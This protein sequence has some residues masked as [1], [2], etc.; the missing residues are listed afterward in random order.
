MPARWQR[1]TAA[2]H[3]GARRVEQRHETDQLETALQTVAVGRQ[4]VERPPR[5]REHA[6]PLRS[7]RLRPRERRRPLRVLQDAAVEDPLRRA[8]HAGD[9]PTGVLLV[10]GRHQLAAGV[11]GEECA[12]PTCSGGHSHVLAV[13]LREGQQR[14]LG[15]VAVDAVAV[16]GCLG[17]VARR[18]DGGEVVL[19]APRLHDAHLVQRQRPG[20]VGADHRRRPERLD[21]REPLH[22][23]ALARQRAH[24]DGQRQRDRGQEPLGDV[25]DEQADGEDERVGE[26][27]AREQPEREER[28]SDDDR[29]DRDQLRDMAH[30]VL[31]RALLAPDALRERGD[32]AELRLH[33]GRE[34]ER[35][36]L[37]ARA[38]RAAEDEVARLEQG[39]RA[40]VARL[41]RDRDGLTGERGDVDLQP[42][43]DDPC[44]GRHPVALLEEQDVA[45]DHGA[46][47]D[48][49]AAALAQDG[50]LRRQ[51]RGKRLDGSLGLALLE[52]GEARVQQDDG[53]DGAGEYRRAGEPREHGR[54]PQE[55][56][57]RM[58]ELDEDLMQPAPA[59]APDD[60]VRPIDEQAPLGLAC[61]QPVPARAER[62]EQQLFAGQRVRRRR[63]RRRRHR[64]RRRSE[65]VVAPAGED[66][67]PLPR[68]WWPR[69]RIGAVRR[70]C[71]DHACARRARRGG[72][73]LP[74]LTL[75]C[76]STSLLGEKR[77]EPT[78]G[79]VPS[80]N[81][82]PRTYGSA[83][84]AR[85]GAAAGP[86][87]ARPPSRRGRGSTRRARRAA[88]AG[89]GCRRCLCRRCRRS[90][91]GSPGGRSSS[92]RR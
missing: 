16:G 1:S 12:A 33:A 72:F 78:G 24:P 4:R 50:H 9:E 58:D 62:G 26:R 89:A 69:N 91:R 87:R 45:D 82:P 64:V 73:G 3:L 17:G 2:A 90:T 48:D 68:A 7:E 81:R 41:A 42:P 36:G 80:R 49:L 15:R 65:R 28:Q 30:L 31:E 20:L 61:R 56:R 63:L 37:A 83:I 53:D 57:E 32:A 84:R 44:V 52:Q 88:P 10:H 35:G 13:L 76:I 23:C 66:H 34:D 25:R 71:G 6:Q 38:A 8:L 85:T 19:V 29:D 5:E 75:A 47:I 43:A 51:V 74:G 79:S 59:A 27:Q 60:L 22:E 77:D 86:G 92:M 11:E 18:S 55:E 54:G 40:R 70:T 67:R 39:V 14:D 46:R 21:G